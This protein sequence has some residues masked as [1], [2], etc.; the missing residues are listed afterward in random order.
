MLDLSFTMSQ[1]T[2]LVMLYILYGGYLIHN[3]MLLFMLCGVYHINDDILLILYGGYRIHNHISPDAI[4]QLC[5]CDN[6][7]LYIHNR[8]V[9]KGRYNT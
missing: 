9:F 7:V 4:L 1:T 3:A 5:Y 8:C 2:I 6:I